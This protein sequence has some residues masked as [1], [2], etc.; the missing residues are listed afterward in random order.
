MRDPRQSSRGVPVDDFLQ[1]IAEQLDK[2]QDSLAL[3]A[4]TG[5]PLTWALRDF[6]IALQVFVELDAATGQVLWRTAGPNESGASTVN[7]EFTTITKPMIE[8]NSYSILDES[9]AR[10]IESIG[11]AA[12]LDDEDKLRLRRLGVRT[13]GQLRRLAPANERQQLDAIGELASIPVGKLEA[14]LRASARPSVQS[15][16]T[17]RKGDQTLLRIRGANLHDGINTEVRLAGEPVEVVDARPNQLLVRPMEHH[18][19]GQIEVLVG[20][21]RATGFFRMPQTAGPPLATALAQSNGAPATPAPS[22]ATPT[23]PGGRP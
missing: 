12:D 6:K 4:R 21:E 13:V 18:S 15:Q 11:I 23:P 10:P 20:G 1:A 22:P 9:D 5:R 8:E 16:D 2:A 3:K 19:S 7:L 14:A 17:V